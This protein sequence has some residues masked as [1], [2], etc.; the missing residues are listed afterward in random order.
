MKKFQ[1]VSFVYQSIVY[2]RK[3]FQLKIKLQLGKQKYHRKQRSHSPASCSLPM[4][5]ITTL[6]SHQ[7]Q[8][9]L[10]L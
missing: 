9:N 8:K 3:I 7:L 4:F 1:L 10:S 6:V 2:V 5:V